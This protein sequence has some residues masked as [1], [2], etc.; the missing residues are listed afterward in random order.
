[1]VNA[2]FG[3]L[4]EALLLKG[5]PSDDSNRIATLPIHGCVLFPCS[6]QHQSGNFPIGLDSL[7]TLDRILFDPHFA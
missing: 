3:G 1:M 6:M 4:P 2:D 5:S 7:V